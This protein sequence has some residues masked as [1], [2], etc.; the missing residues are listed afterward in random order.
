MAKVTSI[1]IDDAGGPYTS[2][3]SILIALPSADSANATGTLVVK[4]SKVDSVDITFG[5]TYYLTGDNGL[6]FPEPLEDIKPARLTAVLQ[7][8]AVQSID[9]DSGGSYYISTPLLLFPTPSGD[10]TQAVASVSLDS[11]G[12]INS[13]NLVDSGLYYSIVPIARLNY[14]IGDSSFSTLLDVTTNNS[15]IS[16]ISVPSGDPVLGYNLDSASV[17]IDAPTGTADQFRASATVSLSD[18]RVGSVQITSNGAGYQSTPTISIESPT[19]DRAQFRATGNLVIEKGEVKAVQITDPGNFYESNQ[20]AISIDGG[21]GSVYDFRATAV[22]TLNAAGEV[23]AVTIT[24]SGNFYLTAP[25][26]TFAAPQE[27]ARFEVGEEVIQILDDGTR[28][29]GEV[30][31]WNDSSYTLELIHVGANDGNYH[32]IVP[33]IIIEGQSSG[34]AGAVLTVTEE[35]QLS[36]TEQNDDFGTEAAD[37]L[38]FTETNPFGEPEQN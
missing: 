32:S 38:D 33:N 9:I 13:I 22:C 37:F 36:A 26:V 24:D 31:L 30:A 23:E 21:T 29:S 6:N 1:S 2:P 3:P 10:A 12:I 27:L 14:L 25:R 28:I 5:G 34:A 18:N 20:T 8:N 17:L 11:S 19:G 15:K 4:S 35:N 7:D 16:S